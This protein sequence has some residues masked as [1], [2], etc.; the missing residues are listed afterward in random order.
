MKTCSSKNCYDEYIG[1][2][3]IGISILYYIIQFIYT[4]DTFDVSSVSVYA[5]I[6]GV[7]NAT[8]ERTII[9]SS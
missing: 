6:L 7:T 1:M 4:T 9:S 3:A 8:H 5:I 2:V